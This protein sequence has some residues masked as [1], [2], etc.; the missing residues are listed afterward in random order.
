VIGFSARLSTFIMNGGAI[1]FDGPDAEDLRG[2]TSGH[3]INELDWEV[4]ERGLGRFEMHNDAV[5]RAADD[6]KI[7][8][9]AAGNGSCLID[10]NARLSVGSGISISGGAGA[11]E[12]VMVIGGNA[13]VEAGN[14]MGAGS[15]LGHTD[16]GYLTMA[17]GGSTG[18]LMIQE[19]A[20]LNIRRLTAR[21]GTSTIIVKDHGQF[22][23]FD[24]L[25]GKGY[26]NATTPPDRPPETGPNSTYASLAPSHAVL[27][28][29]DDAQMTVNSAPAS[30]PTQ[31]LAISG[32][33]DGGNSGGTAILSVRDRASFRVEQ[34]LM[35]GAGANAATSDG[36]LEVVGPNATVSIGGNL[37]MAVD[38]DG[39]IAGFDEAGLPKAGR[40][41]LAAVLTSAT[42]STVQVAGTARIANGV[43]KI[44]TQGY[45]PA[46]GASFTVLKAGAFDGQF[47]R[48]DLSEASLPPGLTAAV[49]YTADSVVVKVVPGPG[50]PDDNGLMANTETFYINTPNLINNGRSE[51][52]GVAIASNGNVIIGWEDDGDALTD[53]ESVWTLFDSAGNSITPD[54]L[55]T[56]IDPA[57]AGQTLTS[58]FLSYFRTDQSAVSGRT[59]WG[60]KIKA[61][62]F[63]DGMG[64]GATS[65]EL[66]LEAPELADI[67][68]DAGGGGDFPSVQVLA[69]DGQP[70]GIRAGVTDAD[71]EPQGDIRIADWDYLANGNIVIVGESRQESDMTDR[72]GGSTP[73]RHAVYRVVNAAG[74]EVKAYGLASSTPE[75]IEM[76][77]GAAVTK[78]GFALRFALANPGQAQRATVRLFDNN[79][80]PTSDNLDLGTLAGD[81]SAAGGG[82]GDSAGF[83]GN[84]NDAYAAVCSA[85]TSVR[86]TVIN[87]DGTLRYTRPVGTEVGLKSVGRT[88]VAI[89]AAGRV[90][91]VYGA[92]YNGGPVDETGA[93]VSVVL[94]QLFDAQGEPLGG[95][96]YVS[97]KEAPGMN[98]LRAR[99]PRVAW[100]GDAVAVAWESLNSGGLSLDGTPLNTVAAR[101]FQAPMVAEP[102]R[103]V[104]IT[105]GASTVTINWTGGRPPYLLQRKSSLGDAQ[106]FNV[107]TTSELRATVG[108]EGAAGFFRVQDQAQQ[109]VIPLTAALSGA[110]EQPT[111]VTT[112][113][114]GVGTFAI[115]G[116]KLYYSISYSGLS[117]PPTAAH[118]HQAAA[119]ASG[120]PVLTFPK[121]TGTSGTMTGSFDLTLALI[122]AITGGQTYANIHTSLN[123]GGEIRGQIVP[124]MLKATLS[125]AAERPDPVTTA[126]NGSA[127]LTLIGDRLSYTVTY[128]DL[129]GDATAGHIHLPADANSTASPKVFFPTVTGKSGAV[130]G[131]AVLK[132]DELDAI[133]TGKAYV[134]IHTSFKGGGEIRGQ[135]M[136]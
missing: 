8:E 23:I 108:A 91:V 72:F 129:T 89:D 86:L 16:E 90:A 15:P 94:G 39:N 92:T 53:L 31:G 116:S 130:S 19:N 3:G 66:G 36:T 17:F 77:H 123:G 68:L 43:L 26:I 103:I 117:G 78:N 127:W 104:S 121:P 122:T 114:S 101:F 52:I 99:N 51:S 113:A 7:A 112:T 136:P 135:V 87:A 84:G 13:L 22:H 102:L 76:W 134:N 85:G 95:T 79:G 38:V 124:L 11:T 55:I 48:V 73:L 28:L 107:L 44:G 42:A 47:A 33:R 128:A 32:Q 98:P 82:R 93:D 75:R 65:F 60:P 61:N 97:E 70:I 10:G 57:Y 40:A 132:P 96:F 109:T 111:P 106:W 14:S 41:T 27:I 25:N 12:Q 118:I 1:L 69:N 21:E 46:N 2:S 126:G 4:G 50:R 20:V 5:F 49:E 59:S 100:R 64:M 115:E 45:T 67:Q 83:D 63:G 24:V 35:V 58:K 110:A 71:A 18:K 54:T 120:S 119:T 9:N 37:N 34:D 6:L 125:G 81:E 133:V 56:S 80:N 30:G 105:A 29:Q 62:L 131:A 74:A 88:D